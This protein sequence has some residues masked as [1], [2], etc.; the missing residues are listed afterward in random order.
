[1]FGAWR[2]SGIR[3]VGDPWTYDRWKRSRQDV[4][5]FTRAQSEGAGRLP[6]WDN[7][8]DL[9]ARRNCQWQI[10]VD[11]GMSRVLGTLVDTHWRR[12]SNE[13]QHLKHTTSSSSQAVLMTLIDLGTWQASITPTPS[14]LEVF[15]S[16]LQ[17]ATDMHRT[18]PS[19]RISHLGPLRKRTCMQTRSQTKHQT[20]TSHPPSWSPFGVGHPATA[21]YRKPSSRTYRDAGRRMH[22][23]AAL[24][25]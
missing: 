11:D 7:D 12:D 8:C 25:I 4:W 18:I 1:M 20:P 23:L 21:L 2:I 3:T 10:Y 16:S 5:V 6:L 15:A 24:R 19:R 22:F 17:S 9:R 13:Q 14:R